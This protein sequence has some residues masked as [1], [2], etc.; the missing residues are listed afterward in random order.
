[1]C[2]TILAKNIENNGDPADY[3]EIFV[4]EPK[5]LTAGSF[6]GFKR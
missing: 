5:P 1:V 2:G 3:R 6:S 4:P